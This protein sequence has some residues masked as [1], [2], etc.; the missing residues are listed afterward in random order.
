[1]TEH[2]TNKM[3]VAEFLRWDDGSDTRYELPGGTSVAVTPPAVA[4][5]VLS[6]RL[7]ARIEAVL[8]ARPPYIGQ[9]EAGIAKPGR[10]TSAISLISR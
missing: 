9:S 2:A 5:R 3:T 8:R 4:H 1:M 7:G 10:T 6:L